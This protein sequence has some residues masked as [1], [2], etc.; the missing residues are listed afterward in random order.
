MKAVSARASAALRRSGFWDGPSAMTTLPRVGGAELR[1]RRM[2]ASD[3]PQC[4]ELMHRR[5]HRHAL[6][7]TFSEAAFRHRFLSGPACSFVSDSPSLAF[8]SFML[9][10]LRTRSRTTLLQAQLLGFASA[11]GGARELLAAALRAAR[12]EGAHVSGARCPV[13]ACRPPLLSCPARPGDRAHFLSVHVAPSEQVFNALEL[14]EHTPLLLNALGF[15]EGDGHTNIHFI[16]P[17]SSSASM[18]AGRVAW[19]PVQ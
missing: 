2:H 7:S 6:A 10:P 16:G 9:V 13:L 8:V 12:R 11:E 3:V 4:I 17:G 18:P 1:L 15:H 19:L 14:A 5:S